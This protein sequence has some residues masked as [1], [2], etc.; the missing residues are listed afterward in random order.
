MIAA[1]D[2]DLL[3]DDAVPITVLGNA[4]LQCAYATS[5]EDNGLARRASRPCSPV[6]SRGIGW[7]TR[8][9][10]RICWLLSTGC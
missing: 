1:T 8:Y 7:P 10:T 3:A 2:G 5:L 6:W 9:R 4:V